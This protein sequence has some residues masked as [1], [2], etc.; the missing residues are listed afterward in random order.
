MDRINIW[1][2]IS[3]TIQF[4]HKAR[5]FYVICCVSDRL[6]YER[7]LQGSSSCMMFVCRDTVM[8]LIDGIVD[9][10][11]RI[12]DVCGNKSLKRVMT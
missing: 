7:D 4:N 2:Q 10:I 11:R 5:H 1:R 6:R 12:S 3:F 9:L 8:D